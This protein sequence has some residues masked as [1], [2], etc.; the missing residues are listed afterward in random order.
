ML[1]ASLFLAIAVAAPVES[2]VNDEGDLKLLEENGIMK[3]ADNLDVFD[4]NDKK[5]RVVKPVYRPP[6]RPP[7][8]GIRPGGNSASSNYL[9]TALL[10]LSFLL[11]FATM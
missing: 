2:N 9:P 6:V 7:V 11:F 3:L 1:F 5:V 8:S 4:V 10:I